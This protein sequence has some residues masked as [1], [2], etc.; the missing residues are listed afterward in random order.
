[1]TDTK[2]IEQSISWIQSLLL[3]IDAIPDEAANAFPA[4]PGF[5]RDELNCF[6]DELRSMHPT[7]QKQSHSG[8]SGVETIQAIR[9]NL[10]HSNTEVFED[11]LAGQKFIAADVGFIN[12]SFDGKVTVAYYKYQ[13]NPADVLPPLP[14]GQNYVLLSD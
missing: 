10:K 6:V 3:Y 14:R 13:G 11:W 4:M 5:D 1:M 2:L 8:F 12:A 9:I 7:A